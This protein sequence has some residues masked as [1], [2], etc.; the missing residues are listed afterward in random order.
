M[1]FRCC[2]SYKGYN[3]CH[4]IPDGIS[5]G[6]ASFVTYNTAQHTQGQLLHKVFYTAGSLSCNNESKYFPSC[7]VGHARCVTA[8]RK[9]DKVTGTEVEALTIFRLTAPVGGGAPLTHIPHF[10]VISL[11][12]YTPLNKQIVS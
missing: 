7:D 1:K 3:I 2:V 5:D 12:V 10:G 9:R 11:N 6:L 4:L 8:S